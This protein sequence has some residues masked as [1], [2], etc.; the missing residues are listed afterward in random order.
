MHARCI[1]MFLASVN[2]YAL[3]TLLFLFL[4]CIYADKLAGASN[5]YYN[6]LMSEQLHA[7]LLLLR[8]ISFNTAPRRKT[9]K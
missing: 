3:L 5:D 4:Y 1:R 6:D 2:V 8:A 7:R 9:S